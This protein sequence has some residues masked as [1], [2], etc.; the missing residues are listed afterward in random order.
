MDQTEDIIKI[1]IGLDPTQE[2]IVTAS[3]KILKMTKTN[4]EPLQFA[5]KVV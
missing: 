3:T 5:H 4:K 2:S 1:L